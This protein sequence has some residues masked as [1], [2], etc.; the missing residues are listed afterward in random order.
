[1][2]QI[3]QRH[4]VAK[5]DSSSPVVRVTKPISSVQ[6]TMNIMF[7]FHRCHSSSAVVALVK[8]ECDLKNL[9]GIFLRS[10]ILLK[11]KN[12][13]RSFSNPI[14]EPV[15]FLMSVSMQNG[16]FLNET[17][18]IISF[19]ILGIRI[20]HWYVLWLV[21]PWCQ[22]ISWNSGDPLCLCQNPLAHFPS[23]NGLE[24]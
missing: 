2:S 23:D 21:F 11:E 3:C 24:S 4:Q 15:K 16:N 12:N 18:C 14:P 6:N 1:M 5:S 7:I 10:T 9:T 22:F 8:Y 20:L 19:R 17:Y 13:A